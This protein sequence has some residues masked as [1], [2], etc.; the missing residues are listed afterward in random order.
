MLIIPRDDLAV[1]A[2]SHT[3]RWAVGAADDAPIV[4]S[5]ANIIDDIDLPKACPSLLSQPIVGDSRKAESILQKRIQKQ[6][7]FLNSRLKA[8]THLS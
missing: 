5:P 7:A 8:G 1:L 4:P 6:I 3:K 2:P